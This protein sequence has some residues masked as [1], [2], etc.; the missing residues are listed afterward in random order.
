[1][2]LSELSARG[3]GERESAAF[4][5]GS[6]AEPIY[7]KVRHV[8]YVDDLDPNALTG[9]ISLPGGAYGPLWRICE[10]LKMRVVAD[11][12][13][14]PASWVGQSLIDAANPM[15]AENGHFALIAPN[16]ARGKIRPSDL[17]VHQ[18]LGDHRWVSVFGTDAASVVRRVWW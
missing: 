3:R 16:F 5:L 8:V 17:G 18:Y 6:P 13:T 15:I 2:M 14:H 4:L 7:P 10:R 12:H 1:M 9:V 11:I